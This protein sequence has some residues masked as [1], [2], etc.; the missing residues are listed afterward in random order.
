MMVATF[1]NHYGAMLFKKTVGAGC[2]LRPVPRSLSS[3]CGTCAVFEG[4][5]KDE[6]YNENLE[7]VYKEKNG[8]YITI[9]EK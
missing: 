6:Y 5:Y 7:A 3:S 4:P 1:A 2:V 8:K 9:V